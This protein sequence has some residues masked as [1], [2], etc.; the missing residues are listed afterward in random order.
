MSNDK[1][2][3]EQ[4]SSFFDEEL[5]KAQN[6]NKVNGDETISL[7]NASSKSNNSFFSDL[8]K[9]EKEFMS[10]FLASAD[11]NRLKIKIDFTEPEIGDKMKTYILKENI[12]LLNKVITEKL[13][14]IIKEDDVSTKETRNIAKINILKKKGKD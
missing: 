6:Q 9:N 5:I 1:E 7:E 13:N 12:Q 4:E 14:E 8:N 11:K 3:K 2:E 10:N